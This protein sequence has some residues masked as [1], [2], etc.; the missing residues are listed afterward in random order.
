MTSFSTSKI[1]IVVPAYNE[2]TVIRSTLKPLVDQGFSVV[3]VDDGSR[4]NTSRRL[5]DLGVYRLRHPFNLGQGAALQTAVSY[6][7]QQG[8][9]FIVHFDAD[10]QHSP[11]DIH[12]L[13]EPVIAGK[14]DVVLGSRFLRQEDWQAVPPTRRL[15]LKGAVFVNWLLTGLW[16]SDAHNGARAFSRRAAQQIVLRENGFAHASEILQQI[17]SMR[18]RFLERPT[19]IRYTKYSLLKGQRIWNALDI[20]VDLV[21]RRVLR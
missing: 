7:L 3:V 13:L 21:I 18:L 6:A 9:A 15:L 11:E 20:F 4:D 17:R 12:G 2:G 1:F 19:R 16:L 10:G 14:A 5:K 8:A